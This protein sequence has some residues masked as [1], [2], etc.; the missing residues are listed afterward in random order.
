MSLQREQKHLPILIAICFV[1]NFIFGGIGQL[2]SIGS[3]GQLFSWQCGSLLFMAGASLFAAKLATDKWHI[4]S[5]GFMLLCIGQG[6]FFSI[7]NTHA[8]ESM[9]IYASGILTFIPGMIFICY[10]SGFPR[11]LRF[12]NL[13]AIIPFILVMVK[14]DMHQYDITNDMKIDVA[15]FVLLQIVGVLW[16]YY[17]I[18]PYH[19]VHVQE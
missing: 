13:I 18:R 16:S 2:F 10:Y 3:F 7:Q 9:Q 11:W 14:I 17:A 1:G 4:S 6:L 19:R 8:T 15:G 12:L 5:A